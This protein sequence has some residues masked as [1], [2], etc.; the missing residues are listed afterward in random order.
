VIPAITAAGVARIRKSSG[1]SPMAF[2]G[3]R[4]TPLSA[5]RNPHWTVRMMN[6]TKN[7][8]RIRN[9]NDAFHRPA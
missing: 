6:E 8:A 3:P 7:G 2:S 4:I 9:R 1:S 5:R